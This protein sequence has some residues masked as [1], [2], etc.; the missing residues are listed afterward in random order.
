[1]KHR[2]VRVP[3]WPRGKAI[4][5]ASLKMLLYGFNVIKDLNV[6][7]D[8]IKFL[9]ETIGR[10][11]LGINRRNIIFNLSPRVMKVKTKINKWDL[12][13]LKSFCTAKKNHKTKRQPIEWE[14]IFATD[15]GLISKIYN[16]FMKLNIKNK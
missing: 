3:P 13:K 7:P 9:E 14:K 11:F 4:S 2:A 6:Q 12:L 5:V 1:M 15:K 16:E 8:A 10:T